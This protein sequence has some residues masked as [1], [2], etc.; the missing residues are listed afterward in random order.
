MLVLL[1]IPSRDAPRN[2]NREKFFDACTIGRSTL[3][4]VDVGLITGSELIVCCSRES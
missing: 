2:R 3:L 1:V 4:A